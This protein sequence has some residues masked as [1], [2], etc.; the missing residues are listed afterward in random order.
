MF[1][2]SF[3]PVYSFL[4]Y[5]HLSVPAGLKGPRADTIGSCFKRPRYSWAEQSCS[6]DPNSLLAPARLIRYP[7][8]EEERNICWG[9]MGHQAWYIVIQ[10]WQ[11]TSEVRGIIIP[12]KWSINAI[13]LF[14]PICSW[15]SEAQSHINSWLLESQASICIQNSFSHPHYRMLTT[16]KSLCG[17]RLFLQSPSE[18]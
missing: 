13:S 15:E 8:W 2:L 3:P 16:L 7:R 10:S 1:A 14:I 12:S 4:Q 6:T 5:F 18:L 17:F 11:P 9:K